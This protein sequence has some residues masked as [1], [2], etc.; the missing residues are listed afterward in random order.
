VRLQKVGAPAYFDSQ[1][2][3]AAALKIDIRDIRDAKKAGCTAFRSGR[4]YKKPLLKWIG[5]KKSK[6][7]KRPDLHDEVRRVFCEA[8]IDLAQRFDA[9]TITADQYFERCA[10]LIDLGGYF[11][12]RPT[13]SRRK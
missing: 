7:P 10:K 6:R 2:L 1:A 13:F 8:M 3:A 4:V 12:K 9:G 11:T 5:Q